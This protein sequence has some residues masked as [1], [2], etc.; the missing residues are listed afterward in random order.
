MMHIPLCVNEGFQQSSIFVN[1]QLKC[2]YLYVTYCNSSDH[3]MVDAE[4]LYLAKEN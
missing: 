4:F 1:A 3:V 2:R